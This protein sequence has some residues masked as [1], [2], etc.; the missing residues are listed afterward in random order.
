M[1]NPRVLYQVTVELP[2]GTWI[3]RN[4]P[5]ANFHHACELA[6]D[7]AADRFGTIVSI[8][9]LVSDQI[10]GVERDELPG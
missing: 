2:N 10:R 6:L 3:W 7:L 1:P 8:Q 5:A 9:K 4:W